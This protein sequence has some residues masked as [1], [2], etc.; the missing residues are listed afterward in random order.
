MIR[1]E[2]ERAIE[3]GLN[4]LERSQQPSGEFPVFASTDPTMRTGCA[5]DP[6]I[7]PTALVCQSLS[8]CP[9]AST[10]R[11][12]AGDFLL[13]EMD[14]AGLWRH[15]THEHPYRH[16][17][18]PDVDD[19]S[20]ASAALLAGGRSL[21]DNRGLLLANRTRRGLFYTWFTPR[22]RWTGRRH[23]ALT[24]AQLSHAPTLIMFFRRTSAAPYDTDAVVNANALFYLAPFDGEQAVVS[25]LLEVLEQDREEQCDKWYDNRFVIWYFLAR[26]LGGRSAAG[27]AILA[28]KLGEARPESA[29]ERALALCA[30]AAIGA[31][32]DGA[33]LAALIACQSGD[34]SWP[35][36]AL[37]HGGRRRLRRGGFDAPHPDTPRWGSEAL[38]TGFAV[39]ALSRALRGAGS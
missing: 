7:Y 20:C 12:R 33:A 25:F 4:F 28:R 8:F 37:Y 22:W 16:Q 32:P 2:A 31:P 38:S 14:A 29:L 27:A 19:T 1:A 11:A 24:L 13:R 26:A 35:R 21:P 30:A 39:E 6:S 17:L 10:L 9:A 3:K 34:G 36:A 23:M 18:P 5:P 15:W